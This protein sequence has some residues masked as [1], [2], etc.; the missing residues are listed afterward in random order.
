MREGPSLQEGWREEGSH[1][2]ECGRAPGA[3]GSPKEMWTSILGRKELVL[4]SG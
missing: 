2:K 4:H 3:E 1:D